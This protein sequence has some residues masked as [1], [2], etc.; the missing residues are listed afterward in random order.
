MKNR[1]GQGYR[2]NIEKLEGSNGAPTSFKDEKVTELVCKW[3]PDATVLSNTS[4]K[5]TY[6]L[7]SGTKEEND[8]KN[9]VHSAAALPQLFRGLETAV[10]EGADTLGIASVGLS[11]TTLEEV[12][13]RLSKE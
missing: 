1:Y 2:L 6:I 12:F 7:P 4:K 5:I 13:L 9:P 10:R 3:F 11:L 8:D